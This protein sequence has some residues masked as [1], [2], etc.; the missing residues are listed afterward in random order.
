MTGKVSV[1][2][3]LITGWPS[4]SPMTLNVGPGASLTNGTGMRKAI[5]SR[6][7]VVSALMMSIQPRRVGCASASS[8]PEGT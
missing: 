4:S 2:L 7:R 8:Q 5:A 3:I 1:P 6:P